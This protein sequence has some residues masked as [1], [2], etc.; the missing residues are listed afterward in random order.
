MIIHQS[1]FL[2]PFSRGAE[3]RKQFMRIGDSLLPHFPGT[4]VLLL[5]ATAPE[6]TQTSL[7]QCLHL[8]F[9]NDLRLLKVN[10]T[11]VP[12]NY[13]HIIRIMNV[14]HTIIIYE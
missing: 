2:S 9:L 13:N 4:P 12:V 10:F 8:Q 6:A 1:N 14:I 3:F 5:T 7:K 11:G